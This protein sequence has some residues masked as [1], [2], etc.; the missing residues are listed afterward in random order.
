M[1]FIETDQMRESLKKLEDGKTLVFTQNFKH[2]KKGEKRVINSYAVFWPDL[3]V[4]FDTMKY[5]AE[6]HVIR[7]DYFKIR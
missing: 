1:D 4:T 7:F 3:H 2:F 5:G 6:P